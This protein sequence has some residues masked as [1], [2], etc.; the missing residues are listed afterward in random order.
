MKRGEDAVADDVPQLV[1]GHAAVQAERGD[2]VQ[3]IDAR[4]RGHV[5]DLFHHQLPDIGRGH[6]RQR[7]RQVVER[8]RQLHAAP[9]QRLQRIVLER[10]AQRSFDRALRMGDGLERVRRVDDA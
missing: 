6:R 7:Q 10:L 1:V 8:D 4:L 3:V 5:D 2:D 9:Q